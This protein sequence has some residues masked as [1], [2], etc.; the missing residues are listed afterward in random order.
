MPKARKT[1]DRRPKVYGKLSEAGQSLL[2][3]TFVFMFVLVPLLVLVVDGIQFWRIRNQLQTATDAACEEA[4]YVGADRRAYRDSGVVRFGNTGQAKADATKT[5]Y[6]TLHNTDAFQYSPSIQIGFDDGIPSSICNAT[7]S[8]QPLI[9][10]LA[11][12]ISI[13][14]ESE[15]EI[16]FSR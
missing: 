7:A 13:Q 11:P 6:A 12:S 10:A 4:A 9:S 16:R 2:W 3:T 14:T 1:G 8:V 5:F 15:S